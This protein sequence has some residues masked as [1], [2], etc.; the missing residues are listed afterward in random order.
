IETQWIPAAE[1]ERVAPATI[2]GVELSMEKLAALPDLAVAKSALT[3]LPTL[4]RAWIEKQKSMIPSE[5]NQRREV[6]ADLLNRA[7]VAAKRIEDG[8]DLLDNAQVREAFCLANK[9]MAIS[10][11]RR[12]GAMQQK[13]P[14]A[15]APPTWRPFQLAFILMNLK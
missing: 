9:A 5:A 6:A 15:V 11:R 2:A 10:A 1:V 12:F 3:G 13:A 14:D 7:T 4:Y 8:I